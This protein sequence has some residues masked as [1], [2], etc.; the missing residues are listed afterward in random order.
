MLSSKNVEA[1]ALTA[2]APLRRKAAV[3]DRYDQPT[4]ADAV[5]C[6]AL[7]NS[8]THRGSGRRDCYWQRC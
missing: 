6:A 7:E 1:D 5:W 2:S 4:R 3:I 8:A